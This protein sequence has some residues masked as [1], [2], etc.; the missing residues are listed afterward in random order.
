MPS[1]SYG[2]FLFLFFF[3]FFSF[4]L[5]CPF[6]PF[7]L[8]PCQLIATRTQQEA[9]SASEHGPPCPPHRHQRSGNTEMKEESVSILDAPRMPA[10]HFSLPHS[11][12]STPMSTCNFQAPRTSIYSG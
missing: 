3:A 1:S 5:L 4:A 8:L 10:T 9:G 2:C 11:T 6:F 12:R 7:F